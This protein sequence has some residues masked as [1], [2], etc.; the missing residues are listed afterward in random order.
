L[1]K[2]NKS[3]LPVGVKEIKGKFDVGEAVSVKNEAGMDIARG[4][5]NFSSENLKKIIGLKTV[6]VEEV[7]GGEY[8]DEVIHRDN[9]VLIEKEL[10]SE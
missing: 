5:V 3:L 1:I 8:V 2:G 4:L 6:Q 9:L 10:K 7:L